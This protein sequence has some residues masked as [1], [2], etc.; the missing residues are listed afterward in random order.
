[1]NARQAS[2]ALFRAI[3]A[4]LCMAFMLCGLNVIGQLFVRIP[5]CFTR[6]L[7]PRGAESPLLQHILLGF[8][9]VLIGGLTIVVAMLRR[10]LHENMRIDVRRNN[11]AAEAQSAAFFYRHR[12]GNRRAT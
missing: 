6:S 5:S 8:V 7:V 4:A 3:D 11:K 9:V 10:E 12:D 2:F 1:M